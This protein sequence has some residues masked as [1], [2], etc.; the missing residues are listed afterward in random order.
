M[1]KELERKRTANMRKVKA[2]I[3]KKAGQAVINQ[4]AGNRGMEEESEEWTN[5]VEGGTDCQVNQIHQPDS[6]IKALVV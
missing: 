4:E 5:Q 6:S 2:W 3:E 1:E